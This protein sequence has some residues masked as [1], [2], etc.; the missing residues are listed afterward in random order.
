[1]FCAFIDGKLQVEPV[2]RRAA[3]QLVKLL[4]PKH[5][6]LTAT[7]S[8]GHEKKAVHALALQHREHICQG[9]NQTVVAGDKKGTRR[10]LLAM[11]NPGSKVLWVNDAIMMLQ[12]LKVLSKGFRVNQVSI[13]KGF[14]PGVV[15]R[16]DT[17]I[18]HDC[19]AADWG[20]PVQPSDVMQNRIHRVLQYWTNEAHPRQPSNIVTTRTALPPTHCVHHMPGCRSES[21]PM[22]RV[23]QPGRSV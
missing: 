22:R 23:G 5:A 1:M 20:N 6:G 8:P 3:H 9:V 18:V 15:G 17:V 12:K 14:A 21:S 16:N 19:I 10:E 11:L 7:R 4:V 2:Q 13:E